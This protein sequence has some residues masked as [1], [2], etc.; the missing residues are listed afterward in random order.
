MRGKKVSVCIPTYE[1]DGKSLFFITKLVSSVLNQTYENLEIVISDH[2]MNDVVHD[3]VKSL[4]TDKITY[5][6]NYENIGYPAFNTNNAI[7]NSQGDFIK[8]MNMDDYLDSSDTILKMVSMLDGDDSWVLSSFKHFN[9]ETNEMYRFMT[10]IIQ[11]DGK[12]L[13]DGI[14]LV[15]CPSVALIPKKE[16]F[17]T[18]VQYMID[19]E[20]WYRLFH[21]YGQP[22]IHGEHDIVI[23]VGSHS[24]SSKIINQQQKLISED[25]KYCHK[26][27]SI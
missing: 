14:N 21:K 18:N 13:L 26:K 4:F 27:F 19:C 8:I 11:G 2:S 3:Y 23:G 15:G 5:I 7:K 12:H 9:Y 1:C 25:I 22:R 20:L 6:K 16:F 24:L 17:D 10:P